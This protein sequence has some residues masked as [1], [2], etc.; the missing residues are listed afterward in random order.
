MTRRE[1]FLNTT[2]SSSHMPC[3]K[4]ACWCCAKFWR[5]KMNP[6]MTDPMPI[7]E[8][9]SVHD[10]A[11][12]NWVLRKINEARA[13]SLHVEQW[14]RAE[15]RRAEREEAFLLHRFGDQLESWVRSQIAQRHDGRKSIFLP[16]GCV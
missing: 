14:A 3:C 5:R 11:S 7:E 6:E 16:A 15:L 10:S 12:A 8:S 9:F 4:L 2:P 13:Y 1:C